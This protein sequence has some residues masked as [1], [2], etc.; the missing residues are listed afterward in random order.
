MIVDWMEPQKDAC[1]YCTETFKNWWTDERKELYMQVMEDYYSELKKLFP[2]TNHVRMSPARCWG[3]GI[4]DGPNITF[5]VA[6]KAG[7]G[8]RY[9]RRGTV[10]MVE[11]LERAGL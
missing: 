2:N 9:I 11:H 6:L 5:S 3:H 7:E 1:K 4:H 10:M 8:Y